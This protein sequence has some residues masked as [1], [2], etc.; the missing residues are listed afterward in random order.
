MFGD[1]LDSFDRQKTISYWTSESS[2]WIDRAQTVPTIYYPQQDQ[3]EESL[4]EKNTP[5][6][7]EEHQSTQQSVPDTLPPDVPT[8][9]DKNWPQ[10]KITEEG[11]LRSESPA[12]PDTINLDMQ[13]AKAR[14]DD[15]ISI[16]LED[17]QAL[18]DENSQGE[19]DSISNS[20]I[21]QIARYD[22]NMAGWNEVSQVAGQKRPHSCEPDNTRMRLQVV[23]L[24]GPQYD[25]LMTGWDEIPAVAGQKRER[26][27]EP[28]TTMTVSKRGRPVKKLDYR[29]PHYG[30]AA[31]VTDNPKS[32]SEAISGPDAKQW[33]KAAE[34]ELQSMIQK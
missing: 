33:R 24:K 27:P 23:G 4:E 29:L 16:S 25:K 12:Q 1:Q 11:I 19:L 34:K 6:T 7:P 17:N 14:Q 15:F 13:V 21:P 31:M 3:T 10:N 2:N 9:S 20:S 5:P 32:W 18:E 22:Q 28:E 8:I 30:K 26:S